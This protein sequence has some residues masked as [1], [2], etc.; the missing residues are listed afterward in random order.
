MKTS[1]TI[2]RP[3][4]STVGGWPALAYGAAWIASSAGGR[5]ICG[6]CSESVD[7]S[8]ARGKT[9]AQRDE[10][11]ARLHAFAKAHRHDDR[12]AA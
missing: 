12:R 9:D 1:S 10:D 6:D 7:T 4:T 3:R 5:W 11:A 8:T 2:E